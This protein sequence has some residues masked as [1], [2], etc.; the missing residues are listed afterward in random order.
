VVVDFQP[1]GLRFAKSTTLSLSYR[2]C[3]LVQGLLLKTAYVDDNRGILEILSSSK[4]N[5]LA[6]TLT[7]KVDHFSGYAIAF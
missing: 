1:Q 6:R 4:N 3:G 2:D 7:S 5:A